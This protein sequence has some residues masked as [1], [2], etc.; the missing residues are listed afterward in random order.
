MRI[1]PR[2]ILSN[3]GLY[4]DFIYLL[5][6]ILHFQKI[7]ECANRLI[8]VQVHNYVQYLT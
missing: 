6:I 8:L 2:L 7:N 1:V 4:N 3:K 5:S